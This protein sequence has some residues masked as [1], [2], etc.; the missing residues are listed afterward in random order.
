MQLKT[1]LFLQII[2][3][4]SQSYDH[5]ENYGNWVLREEIYGNANNGIIL[6][7]CRIQRC[8]LKFKDKN[9]SLTSSHLRNF[10][11][12]MTICET[13]SC[14]NASATTP[15]PAIFLANELVAR[16][17][18]ILSSLPHL[19][20]YKLTL[21]APRRGRGPNSDKCYGQFC[22][23]GLRPD[24]SVRRHEK[25]SKFFIL[26]HIAI[27]EALW[28]VAFCI[29]QCPMIK[30]NWKRHGLVELFI[31]GGSSQEH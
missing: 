7:G 28:V 19:H 15:A 3:R 26:V 17:S 30:F 2:E 6:E 4:T 18:F 16:A 24:F 11:G 12:L 21:Y 13:E 23:C 31:Q 1:Q 5:T 27:F 22:E 8:K 14:F 25:R 20:N 9:I 29:E 10:A